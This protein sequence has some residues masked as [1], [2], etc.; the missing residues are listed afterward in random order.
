[1]YTSSAKMTQMGLTAFRQAMSPA[2]LWMLLYVV[3][4]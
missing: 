4:E 2:A 1:M 3:R